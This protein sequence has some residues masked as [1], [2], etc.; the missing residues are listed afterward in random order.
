MWKMVFFNIQIGFKKSHV[1]EPL[2]CVELEVLIDGDSQIEGEADGDSGGHDG[3]DTEVDG[4]IADQ[5]GDVEPA[6]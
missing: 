2:R 1:I 5:Q 6:L 3:G 4:D